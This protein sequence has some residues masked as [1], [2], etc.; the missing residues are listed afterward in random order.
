ML[1]V[2]EPLYQA[3]PQWASNQLGLGTSTFARGGCLLMSLTKA[4]H[5][6]RGEMLSPVEVHESVVRASAFHR[7]NMLMAVG[8]ASVGLRT[9]ATEWTYP[10]S[11][12]SMHV[13]LLILTLAAKGVAVVHV[14]HDRDRRNGD[15]EPD[16]FVLATGVLR[17]DRVAC[18][19]SVAGIITLPLG[20]LTDHVEWYRYDERDGKRDDGQPATPTSIRTYRVRGVRPL[21]AG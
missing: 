18:L 15:Q 3:D 16:H 17:D 5:I 20:T 12:M 11:P 4:V 19:D 1:L 2:D 14:D 10:E 6:L 8:A 21:F 9:K 7:S 13:N